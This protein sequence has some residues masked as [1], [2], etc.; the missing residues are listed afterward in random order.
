M[1]SLDEWE[2]NV[3]ATINKLT[4]LCLAVL[5]PAVPTPAQHEGVFKKFAGTYVTGHG[6]GGD[7]LTLEADGH[8][9]KRGGSDDGTQI[10]TSGTY[11]L[12][13]GRLRFII[14]KHTGRLGSEGKEFNLLD[15]NDRKEMFGNSD[16]GE[17]EREFDMLP[18]QWSGRIYLLH[19]RDLSDFANAVNLGIEPRT[20]LISNNY[21]SPWY[22]SFYLRSGD[23]QKK[24]TGNPSLPEQWLSFLLS[25][26]VT[27]KVIS[28]EEIKKDRWNTTFTGTINKG[29]RDGLKVGMRLLTEDEDPSPWGGTEVISAAE[30]TAKIRTQ[31]V[32]SELKVGDKISSRYEPKDLYK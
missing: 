17:I 15:P 24:V 28:I 25:K 23:E 14:V 3:I 29:S 12:S 4:L 22:G 11:V 26:P 2:V 1:L 7:S 6:Y 21:S 32:R 5:L 30:K 18:L 19:E 9:S 31:L 13:D 8:F 27:A 10:S 20:T 16:A